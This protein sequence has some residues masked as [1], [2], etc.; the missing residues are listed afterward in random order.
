MADVATMRT[1]LA[2]LERIH[3]EIAATVRQLDMENRRAL[4]ALRRQLAEQ[5]A[6]IGRTGDA[7]FAGTSE[8]DEYRARFGRM[9]SQ[10]A[11]HQASWPA[12]RLGEDDAAFRASAMPVREA[13][14]AFVTWT[15]SALD[16]MV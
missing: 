1:Q 13:N 8:L 7:L 15:K 2:A 11:I 14:R 4:I 3:S 9:R 6:V 10:S 5:I 16:R 12:V